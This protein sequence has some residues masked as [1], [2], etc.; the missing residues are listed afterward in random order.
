MKMF[1]K[2]QILQN[3]HG[4]SFHNIFKVYAIGQHLVEEFYVQLLKFNSW[5]VFHISKSKKH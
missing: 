2:Y 4:F 1:R 5:H 3:V